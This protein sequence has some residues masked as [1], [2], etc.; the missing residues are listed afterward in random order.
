MQDCVTK[1]EN[2]LDP[3]FS[4]SEQAQER[5]DKIEKDCLE[6]GLWKNA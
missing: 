3:Y 2:Y 4:E 1:L 5:L 6:R